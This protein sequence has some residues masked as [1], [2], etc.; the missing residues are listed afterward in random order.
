MMASL[1]PLLPWLIV[2]LVSMGS[3]AF[4]S[5]SES[6]LF[7]LRASD[8]LRMAKGTAGERMAV[9]L[10][11]TPDR[12]LA[13]ILFF[14]LVSN[15]LI[16]AVSS[17]CAL[18]I[19]KSED[20]S[21]V[22]ATMFAMGTLL[23]MIF[24]CEMFPKTLGVMA[25]LWLA[26]KVSLP[27]AILVRLVSPVLP[28]IQAINRVTLRVIWPRFR[29]ENYL[30]PVDLERAIQLSSSDA[31]IIEHEQTV[32]NNIVH[33]SE[34]RVD[35]WM[36][37]RTQFEIFRPPVSLA[38]LEGQ[39]PAGGYLLVSEASSYEVA[40]AIRLDS[41]YQLPEHNLE[42]LADRVLYL[43]WCA[44]VADA[45]E[46]MTKS[47]REV[48]AVVNEYG[49]S[50]GILTVED[51]F[52]TIFSYAP[53]RSKRLLD[54]NPLH[55]ISEGR[56]IVAGIMSLRQLARKLEVPIPP[57]HSVTVAGVIQEQMQ[58]LAEANDECE[59][60]PFHFRVVETGERGHLIVELTMRQTPEVGE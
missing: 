37:P 18:Q 54:R 25:P 9:R 30:E 3:S 24:F 32:L 49:E 41:H 1:L 45:L 10:L 40:Q 11:A 12:L 31:S 27:L 33:L 46:Q 56:W 38:D 48:T 53:S 21:A 51:I 59:W 43:P 19:E 58:R 52:E 6:A 14:N 17:I 2:M 55:P 39:V 28:L 23:F 47:E 35:E 57:T 20:F 42:T 13:A 26:P 50:I 5:A 44:T 22:A 29:T 4:F 8:K 7:Y 60:G 16:F 34:I 15:I 36:R